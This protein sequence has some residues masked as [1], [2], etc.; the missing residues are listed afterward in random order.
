MVFD[1]WLKVY[2][3]FPESL[4][5]ILEKKIW[6]QGDKV[7]AKKKVG[8]ALAFPPLLAL[9][10]TLNYFAFINSALL[11]VIGV[12][13]ISL[14]ATYFVVYAVIN[15]YEMSRTNM[16]ESN[17]PNA[18]E[19]IATNINSGL[20]VE[21]ALV[22]SSRPEF[23]ELGLLLK[24]AAKQMFSGKSLEYALS[25]VSS[26][27][28]SNVLQ[29]TMWLITEGLNKGGSFGDLLLRI[30]KDLREE[31]AIKNEINANISMYVILILIA[32]AIGAPLLFGAGTFVSQMMVG[33]ENTTI[34]PIQGSSSV[35]LMG[36]LTSSGKEKEKIGMETL[37]LFSL[38]SIFFT[39][40]FASMLLGI[41][42]YNK[43]IAGLKYFPVLLVIS[44]IVYY[45]S[46]F[47]L[48]NFI[49]VRAFNI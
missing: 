38:A 11:F 27:V 37:T 2:S 21:S 35:P 47:M 10:I 49:G 40:F 32:S 9:A 31:S 8:F 28:N 43:E 25:S 46:L 1:V 24:L 34:S 13:F 3:L 39:S 45:V 20:T 42:K 16:I 26:V 6:V 41:I 30:A 4:T 14:I 36:L 18:L 7:K 19:L 23:G 5:S 29:K 17:L 15:Y 22:E 33:Q 44:I 48:Q 12:F